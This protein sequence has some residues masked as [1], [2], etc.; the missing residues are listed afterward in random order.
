MDV[1]G[2][3]V[4]TTFIEATTENAMSMGLMGETINDGIMY[5]I[6]IYAIYKI[7]SED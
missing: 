4:K 5:Q 2:K 6:Q 3:D 1:N 7:E